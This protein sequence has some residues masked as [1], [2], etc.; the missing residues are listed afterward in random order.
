MT[1]GAA[2]AWDA[3]PCQLPLA[4]ICKQVPHAAYAYASNS[5]LATYVYNST[6]SAFNHAQDACN[7]AGG[8]LVYYDSVQEQAELEAW[9]VAAG[10]FVP[11]YHR[12]VRAH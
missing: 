9:L 7:S 5:S 6:P 8:H 2:W 11:S 3:L 1:D 4:F 12:W 10:H